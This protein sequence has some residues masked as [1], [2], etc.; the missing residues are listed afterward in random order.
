M[1]QISASAAVWAIVFGFSAPWVGLL[2]ARFGVRF[3]MLSAA[4][5]SAL[6]LLGIKATPALRPGTWT[7]SETEYRRPG[8]RMPGRSRGKSWGPSRAVLLENDPDGL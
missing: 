3:T 1:T 6:T 7:R 4:G 2:I 5:A 8:P